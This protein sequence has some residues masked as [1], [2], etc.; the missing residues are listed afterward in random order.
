MKKT[1][2]ILSVMILF[3]GCGS[4]DEEK[5]N[6]DVNKTEESNVTTLPKSTSVDYTI[7]LK[8]EYNKDGSSTRRLAPLY[9][10]QHKEVQKKLDETKSDSV[11]FNL[12]FNQYIGRLYRGTE[13]LKTLYDYAP[14]G[15]SKSQIVTVTNGQVDYSSYKLKGD[16]DF[17]WEVNVEDLNLLSDAILNDIE[18]FQYDVN[19]DGKVDTADIIDVA[20]RFGNEIKYFDFYT[21]DGEKLSID[22]RTTE[23]E[24]SFAYG[25]TETKVIVVAKDRNHASAY[26]SGLSDS[27]DVWYKQDG[28]VLQKTAPVTNKLK[29]STTNQE[30][31]DYMGRFN[32]SSEIF[33][34]YIE[35]NNYLVGCDFTL[36]DLGVTHPNK[37][38]ASFT[39]PLNEDPLLSYVNAIE[40][41][42]DGY[43]SKTNMNH[44]PI[45]E[46][47]AK[48]YTHRV[49]ALI[50]KLYAPI[51][52]FHT[53]SLYSREDKENAVYEAEIKQEFLWNTYIYYSPKSYMLVGELNR[54]DGKEVKGTVVA[55]RIGPDQQD[56]LTGDIEDST[57]V[58]EDASFGTYTIDYIDRCSC[59][60]SL[61]VYVFEEENPEAPEFRIKE[62][63]VKVKLE[64]LDT[65]NKPIDGKSIKIV[66][67]E[68]VS[69]D[70]SEKSF[71]SVTDSSG[72]VDFS[73]VPIGDYTVYIDGKENSVIHFCEAYNG[74]LSTEELW[75][76]DLKFEAKPNNGSYS[77]YEE[78]K[79][80]HWKKVRFASIDDDAT[81]TGDEL[82]HLYDSRE[83]YFPY[84][85]NGV[86]VLGHTT[87]YKDEHGIEMTY[88]HEGKYC[89][90]D[91]Q[92][93]IK[94]YMANSSGHPEIDGIATSLDQT[95]G[96]TDLVDNCTI[97][98]GSQASGAGAI[99]M[100]L[101]STNVD[102]LVEYKSFIFKESRTWGNMQGKSTVTVTFTPS[103]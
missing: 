74:K 95:Y 87:P 55:G 64:L 35:E 78:Y 2:L 6:I 36:D 8:Y 41:L 11:A 37:K 80:W 54:D 50:D 72:Y 5:K 69:S 48:S 59:P 13:S 38:Y 28:W 27:D 29:S 91:V 19:G 83:F 88:T 94:D 85:D 65:D 3:A 14:K 58:V 67:K 42:V 26:E 51:Q 62:N 1:I 20:A 33:I 15:E 40:T 24:K 53:I 77:T 9:V 57:F 71:S 4:D 60:S 7:P 52:F 102:N 39:M 70:S 98:L 23:E 84:E 43:F 49:G 100:G 79:E 12:V 44:P 101:S 16:V 63:K 45:S 96:V 17:N 97:R 47:N 66:A 10:N 73:D 25:G 89:M 90:N 75:D 46:I 18:S 103:R 82:K 32:G 76:I 99:Y 21:K 93:L 56:F 86:K 81:H 30:K 61:G 22:T 68:C 34:K 31:L 92:K